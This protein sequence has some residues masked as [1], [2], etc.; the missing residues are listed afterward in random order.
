M[1]CSPF[2]CRFGV[3]ETLGHAHLLTAAV[4]EGGTGVAYG[5][6]R[7]GGVWPWT[8]VTASQRLDGCLTRTQVFKF[9]VYLA[10][11]ALLTLTFVGVPDNMQRV[12]ANVRLLACLLSPLGRRD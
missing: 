8:C 6:R 1:R 11:P 10:V 2:L 7:P 3:E 5:T 4:G 12:I 9:G